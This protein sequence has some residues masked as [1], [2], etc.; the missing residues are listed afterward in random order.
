MDWTTLQ[1][2]IKSWAALVTGLPVVWENEARP[3][4]I[5]TPGYV[6]LG[7]PS[8]ITPKGQDWVQTEV[9]GDELRPT[10]VGQRIFTV[11]FRVLTRSQ[12]PAQSAR[13]YTERARLSLKM[14]SV[15]AT[16]QAAGLAVV[17]A[18]PTKQFDAPWDERMESIAAF[19]LTLGAAVALQDIGDD[20]GTI[21][22]VLLSAETETD[23]GAT[24]EPPD[25][26]DF[27]VEIDP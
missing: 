3:T 21:G 14:P 26:T 24:P 5:R 7:T 11:S 18:E 1:A 19:E 13:Y 20:L 10:V 12:L 9:I 17:R 6:I 27:V 2:A 22:S 16:L 4:I 23:S 8:D 15:L 25:Y